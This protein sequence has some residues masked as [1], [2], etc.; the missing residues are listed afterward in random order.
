MLI[1]YSG[2]MSRFLLLM[3]RDKHHLVQFQFQFQMQTLF[4]HYSLQPK[5]EFPSGLFLIHIYIQLCPN[6]S[7][8]LDHC[9]H[10]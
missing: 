5:P 6:P 7:L 1:L 3:N 2:R 10:A 8:G 9:C 4:Q